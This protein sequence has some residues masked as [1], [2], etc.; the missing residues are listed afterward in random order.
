MEKT[1]VYLA[2]FDC[3]DGER[4]PRW[5]LTEQDALGVIGEF[6]DDNYG[7]PPDGPYEVETYVG[8]NVY[9]SACKANQ[10]LEFDLMQ[11]DGFDLIFSYEGKE[12][13]AYFYYDGEVAYYDGDLGL[14]TE[15]LKIPFET[16]MECPRYY[17]PE[18]DRA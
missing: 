18:V 11:K 3:G 7:P 6:E 10:E 4:F 13:Y 2:I 17:R 15:L 9:N 14:E 1:K 16:F 5:F 8:S 12:Y